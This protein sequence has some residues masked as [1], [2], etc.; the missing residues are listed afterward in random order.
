MTKWF[1]F[2]VCKPSSANIQKSINTIQYTDRL[3]KIT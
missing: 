1:L 2:Q 3:K